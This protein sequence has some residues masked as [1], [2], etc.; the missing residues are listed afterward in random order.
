MGKVQHMNMEKER[1]RHGHILSI[2]WR[3]TNG[4]PMA[5]IERCTVMASKGIDR[6]NRKYGKR[7]VTFL[8][9]QAWRDVCKELGNEIP[10][11]TRRAN[12]L[13][14]GIDLASTIKK[15]ITI[16]PVRIYVHGETKPCRLMDDQ[17]DG[18]CNA[19]T[20]H[21]RGGVFGQVLSGGDIQVGDP[22]TMSS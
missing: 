2:A 1:H 14:D 19:L 21:C 20:P 13:I 22:V 7:E 17:Y 10:W 3:P 18:L 9:A 16:G 5:E 11:V 6:E 8:S 12:F 4:D 15:T